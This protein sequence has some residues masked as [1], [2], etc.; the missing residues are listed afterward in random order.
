MKPPGIQRLIFQRM[1]GLFIAVSLARY[2]FWI[3]FEL[4]EISDEPFDGADLLTEFSVMLSIDLVLVPLAVGILWLLALQLTTPLRSIAD[5]CGG[6]AEGNLGGR[7]ETEPLPEGEITKVAEALN[8]AFD[9]HEIARD[10]ARS[11]TANASHQLRNPL[12]G[13]QTTAQ[14]ALGIPGMPEA[15]IVAVE[16]ILEESLRLNTMCEKLL[17]LSRLEG[18]TERIQAVTEVDALVRKLVDV[19]H[20]LAQ[21]RGLQMGVKNLDPGSVRLDASLGY[22]V[23]A[24][25]LSNAINAGAP[26]GVIQLSGSSF[27]E[28]DAYELLIEDSGAG[29]PDAEREHVFQRFQQGAHRGAGGHGLGLALCDQIIRAHEGTLRLEESQT[30]KGAAFRITLHLA[31]S[32]ER[33]V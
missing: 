13:I 21:S 16:N 22:E 25:L 17:L 31:G 19:Y 23:I 30:L 11:F 29:V 32:L 7:I 1:L 8:A 5:A 3:A 24:N 2:I 26:G 18:S 4:F 20:E 14:S 9:R 12:A 28:R 27:P 33:P 10:Q 6:I 15:G